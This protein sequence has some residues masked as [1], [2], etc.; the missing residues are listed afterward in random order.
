MQK[1]KWYQMGHRGFRLD[2]TEKRT[3]VCRLVTAIYLILSVIFVIIVYIIF[4]I[5]MG[6]GEKFKKRLRE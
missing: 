5:S 1:T 6:K 2:T 3:N 4:W